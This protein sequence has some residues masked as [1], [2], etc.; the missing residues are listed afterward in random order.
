MSGKAKHLGH[1]SGFRAIWKGLGPTFVGIHSIYSIS[2]K[3]PI[4]FFFL[5][6]S[7]LFLVSTISGYSIQG[8]FKFGLYEVFKQMGNI[9]MLT[10]P[11]PAPNK[12]FDRL[13][14][15]IWRLMKSLLL[16]EED[17]GL[18]HRS[19]KRALNRTRW[20][21][22]DIAVFDRFCKQVRWFVHRNTRDDY[23]KEYDLEE[24]EQ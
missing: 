18:F 13:Y 22:G 10:Y 12:E 9:P 16:R 20:T 24:Q 19:L 14:D 5:S 2:F 15:N 7:I 4:P 17:K 1:T 8:A 3:F 11:K 23:K 6:F 21:K